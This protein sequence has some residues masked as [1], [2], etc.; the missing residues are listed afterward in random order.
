MLDDAQRSFTADNLTRS[1][2]TVKPGRGCTVW[3]VGHSTLSLH[4]FVERLRPEAISGLADVRRFPASRR[5]PQFDGEALA[6]GLAAAG[7]EYRWFEALGGRRSSRGESP[8]TNAGLRVSGFRAYA[9]YALTPPFREALV[10]ILEWA[11]T[12]RV[13]VCCAEGVWWQCHRRIIS[14]HLV[15]RGCR[16]LHVLPAGK[17][18]EHTLWELARI[19]REGVVYPPLQADV[20]A[21]PG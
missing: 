2:T 13:A 1:D 3:T 20:F 12:R 10:E 7:V 9:D 14:D 18:A 8:A 17:I 19:T 6:Q 21:A 16:V 11:R 15:A 5:H 4:D